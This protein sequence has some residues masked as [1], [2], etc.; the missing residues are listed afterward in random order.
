MGT[1]EERMQNT[2]SMVPGVDAKEK[3][4]WLTDLQALAANDNRGPISREIV[5]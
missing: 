5:A 1:K 3:A 2:I 4:G